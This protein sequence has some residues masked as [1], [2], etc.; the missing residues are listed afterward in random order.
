MVDTES[1]QQNMTQYVFNKIS[2]LLIW[3]ILNSFR[4]FARW[5]IHMEGVHGTLYEGEQFQL[6]FKFNNK[7]PFD[8]PE[9]TFIGSNIPVHPHVY[10]NGHICLSILTEDWYVTKAFCVRWIVIT[11][12]W[13][14]CLGRLPYRC[15]P[16]AW[17]YRRCSAVAAK[18]SDRQTTH[19]MWKHAIRIRK[20]QNGGI[21]VISIKYVKCLFV[22]IVCGISVLQT[23]QCDARA[24]ARVFPKFYYLYGFLNEI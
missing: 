12:D 21:T 14:Y 22:L 15:N 4:S 9:V 16:Y 6:L 11:I 5:K 8:S 20:R 18:R 13:L 19:C 17:V 2:L 1:I 7:Y 3:T 10:S 23:I 24:E